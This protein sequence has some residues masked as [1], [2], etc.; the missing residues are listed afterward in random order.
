M[1]ISFSELSLRNELQTA[2][3][4]Q[5]YE[6]PTPIQAKAIPHA[7]E[8]RDVIG[9]AQT[10]TGKTAAFTLPLLQRLSATPAVGQ[11]GRPR[12]LILTPT[13]EL[14]LQ[15]GESLTAYGAGLRLRH[16]VIFGG[17]GQRPQVEALRRGLDVLVATPGRLLDLMNQRHVRL[18]GIGIFVLDEA[19][20]M[21]D[22]GF[23]HDVR[24][25]TGQLPKTRQTLFFSAT[26]PPEISNLAAQLL[27]DPVR[28]EV[29]PAATTVDRVDQRVMFVAGADKRRLLVHVLGDRAM[30]KVIVFTRT[31]RGADKVAR[32]LEV[33]GIAVAAIHG[34]KSQGARQAALEAFRNGKTRVLV[35]TDIAARGIDVDGVSHVVNYELPNVPESYVHRVGRTAR[36]GA[37]GV[38]LS[39]CDQDE[40]IYLRDIE[41][42]IRKRLTVIGH[43]TADG[44]IAASS[45][46]RP[47]RQPARTRTERRDTPSERT[48]KRRNG[49]SRPANAGLRRRDR[50]SGQF[51]DFVAAFSGGRDR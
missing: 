21:L 16:A 43:P 14:A 15:I 51:R 1:T 41:K 34:N 45:D 31:K 18:D 4:V 38:A 50:S 12:A 20:R 29:A 17:V 2:L 39:F 8:G 35:A 22:M 6:T 44:P 23:I 49:S 7:L 40:R 36:A 46:A 26:M 5:G 32:H 30:T 19:D 33:A 28:I 9:L 24:R 25:I 13:R 11:S 42:L 48:G 47:P 3:R 37:D 27:R 10:G